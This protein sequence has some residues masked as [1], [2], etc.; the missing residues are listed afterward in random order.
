MAGYIGS[1]VSELSALME[2]AQLSETET[3]AFPVLRSVLRPTIDVP[4]DYLRQSRFRGEVA[5]NR[6]QHETV[7]GL[8]C[9][10][11]K[12]QGP[13][14]T[15]KSTTIFHMITARLPPGTRVLVTCSR[16]VAVESIAQKLQVTDVCNCIRTRLNMCVA[17]YKRV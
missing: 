6:S 13:P 9:A 11:E 3:R 5:I 8:Q 10:L 12:V 4:G 16:N 2:L 14:G 1:Y 15:G 17:E 7:C